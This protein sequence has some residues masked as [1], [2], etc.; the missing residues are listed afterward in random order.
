VGGKRV[1]LY[2]LQ[3]RKG[4]V[5]MPPGGAAVVQYELRT[6]QGGRFIER[7]TLV[8]EKDGW[9]PVGYAFQSVTAR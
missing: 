4:S 9:R 5:P 1:E 6:S 7:V 8:N 2:R 3:T